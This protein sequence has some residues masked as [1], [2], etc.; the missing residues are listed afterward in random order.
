MNAMTEEFIRAN[1][2]TVDWYSVSR[3][4]TLSLQFI[5][6]FR[7]YA[8]WS[9]ISR[10][11]KLTEDFI[12]HYQ[13]DV[14]WDYISTYQTLSEAFI[15]EFEE[16]L[17][18]MNVFRFQDLSEEYIINQKEFILDN[19]CFSWFDIAGRK[20]KVSEQ[21]IRVFQTKLKSKDWDNISLHQDLSFAFVSEF[22]N[23]INMDNV[24][25]HNA[26]KISQFVANQLHSRKLK[27]IKQINLPS[28]CI[29]SVASYL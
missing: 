22:K 1:R 12:R 19:E 27:I 4:C 7:D 23:K 11:Q 2:D 10:K 14:D 9:M 26:I 5:T 8:D 28:H 3:H 6:E 24:K 15:D 20:K 17:D 13:A 21:F 29:A 18:W 25:K 16:Y